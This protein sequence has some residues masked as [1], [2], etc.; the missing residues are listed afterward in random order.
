MLA[1]RT[2]KWSL[3]IFHHS[4]SLEDVTRVKQ[5]SNILPIFRHSSSQMT[6][7]QQSN[8]L[9]WCMLRNNFYARSAPLDVRWGLAH[10]ARAGG[11]RHR[12]LLRLRITLRGATACSG[13]TTLCAATPVKSPSSSCRSNKWSRTFS[14]NSISHICT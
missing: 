9:L 4:S 2:S 13:G 10:L 1:V 12:G 14:H 3:S 8:I 6:L 5:Q 11:P 7:K